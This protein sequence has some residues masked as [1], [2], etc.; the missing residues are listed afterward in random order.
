MPSPFLPG[1]HACIQFDSG[2]IC[3]SVKG[4]TN[5]PGLLFS[6]CVPPPNIACYC[7][8]DAPR[9][10]NQFIARVHPWQHRVTVE[11]QPDPA[12]EAAVEKEARGS[13]LFLTLPTLLLHVAQS[14]GCGHD[15]PSDPVYL[16]LHN[17]HAFMAVN[18]QCMRHTNHWQDRNTRA[19]SLL[20]TP[21]VPCL[22]LFKG[23]W[24]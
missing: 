23:P 15:P 21:P 8:V 3:T 9:I 6:P 10:W 13:F 17:S 7:G 12:F 19:V 11:L 5:Y 24:Q 18:H 16:L 1:M 4:S 20:H 22:V 2:I 14:S